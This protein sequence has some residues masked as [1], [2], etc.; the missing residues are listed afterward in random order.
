MAA[1]WGPAAAAS[2]APIERAL[3]SQAD[4]SNSSLTVSETGITNIFD[5]DSTQIGT[6]SFSKELNRF[7]LNNGDSFYC[8]TDDLTLV[9]GKLFDND[10]STQIQFR[11]NDRSPSG[12]NVYRFYYEPQSDIYVNQLTI[13]AGTNSNGESL[14]DLFVVNGATSTSVTGLSLTLPK[15]LSAGSS[16]TV[17][18]DPVVIGPGKPLRIRISEI[19]ARTYLTEFILEYTL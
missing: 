16:R 11:P 13:Y 9:A 2:A 1:K 10:L 15:T 17:T 5:Y 19:N 8:P 7:V 4:A 12:L 18:F 6:I 14:H 3:V